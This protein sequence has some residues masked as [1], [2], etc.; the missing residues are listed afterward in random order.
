MA[1]QRT[2]PLQ[3]SQLMCSGRLL[4]KCFQPFFCDLF[5]PFYK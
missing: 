1:Q 4:V 2:I 3:L 5:L